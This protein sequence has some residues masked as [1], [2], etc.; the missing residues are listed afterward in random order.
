M[1][2]DTSTLLLFPLG[3]LLPIA[4]VV[5]FIFCKDKKSVAH[6]TVFYGIGSFLGSMIAAFIAFLLVNTILSANFSVDDYESGFT[7]V[8]TVFAILIAVIF[9][10]CESLKMVTVKKFISD[11]KRNRFSSLGFSAGVIIAQNAIFFVALNVFRDTD[12]TWSLF[13]GAFI[14]VTGII[15]YELSFAS[16]KSLALGSKGAA[17]GLSAVYYL[18]W[19]SIV[20]AISSSILIVFF[21]AFFFVISL[22]LSY[23]FIKRKGR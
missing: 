10:I 7:L 12:P 21:I 16:E 11:E 20:F 4:T 17:Y 13:T 1:G 19:I 8:S 6:D 18:M 9:V 23:I 14:F 15:Y 2:F 5:F 22:I 3:L